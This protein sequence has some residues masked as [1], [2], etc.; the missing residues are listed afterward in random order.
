[1]DTATP[2]DSLAPPATHQPPRPA[3]GATPAHPADG[4]FERYVVSAAAA[5]GYLSSALPPTFI[6]PLLEHHVRFGPRTY[7]FGWW[8]GLGAIPI[9]L[10]TFAGL[11]AVS[12][13]RRLL[14]S[15]LPLV[16]GAIVL[17]VYYR[18][19]FPHANVVTWSLLY[20]LLALVTIWLRS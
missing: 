6:D 17:F 13:K 20:A 7:P 18:Q 15:F 11:G 2:A 10:A 19:E 1:M 9:G 16:L 12:P 8:I 5:A 4:S 3:V 14:F